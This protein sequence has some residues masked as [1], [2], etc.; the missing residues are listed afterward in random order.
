MPE[1]VLRIPDGSRV[2]RRASDAEAIEHGRMLLIRAPD[3]Q[4]YW[5]NID[6]GLEA[7]SLKVVGD[8]KAK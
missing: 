3:G 8:E 6:G 4:V 1:I 7:V 2:I 5:V